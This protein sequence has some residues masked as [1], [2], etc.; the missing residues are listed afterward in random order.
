[1]ATFILLSSV[2]EAGARTMINNP[3]QILGSIVN[4]RAYAFR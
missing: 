3:D 4:W 2:T 1:M